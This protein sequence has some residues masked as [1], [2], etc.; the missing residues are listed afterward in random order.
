MSANS[1][2]R[3][4]GYAKVVRGTAHFPRVVS[5]P[6]S[7]HGGILLACVLALKPLSSVPTASRRFN[8]PWTNPGLSTKHLFPQ[9]FTLE[10]AIPALP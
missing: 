3:V 8:G 2:P 9:D 5:A 10:N 6:S 7:F 4:G 1:M